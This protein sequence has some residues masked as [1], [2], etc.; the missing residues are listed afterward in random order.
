MKESEGEGQE[1]E[2]EGA[3]ILVCVYLCTDDLCADSGPE[4]GLRSPSHVLR[5]GF[6]AERERLPE[7][8]KCSCVLPTRAPS[9]CYGMTAMI[10]PALLYQHGQVVSCSCCC[11]N[12]VLSSRGGV[13]TDAL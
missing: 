12:S 1:E 6:C 7:Q 4:W 11:L 13:L 8:P 10:V 9:L 3:Q 5:S 2:Y